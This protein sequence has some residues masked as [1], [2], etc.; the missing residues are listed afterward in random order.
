MVVTFITTYIGRK[1]TW[2]KKRK[3]RDKKKKRKRKR[4]ELLE[5]Y[6]ERITLYDI[7]LNSNPKSKK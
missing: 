4:K 2:K 7:L 5:K 6:T 1:L 3:E